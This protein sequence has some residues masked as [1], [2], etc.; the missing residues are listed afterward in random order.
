MKHRK[1]VQRTHHLRPLHLSAPVPQAVFECWH[2]AD[3]H[4]AQHVPHCTVNCLKVSGGDLKANGRLVHALRKALTGLVVVRCPFGRGRQPS[5]PRV[6]TERRRETVSALFILRRRHSASK[7]RRRCTASCH[8]S[9][10]FTQL[11]VRTSPVTIENPPLTVLP[12]K[13]LRISRA[14]VGTRGGT[15]VVDVGYTGV[16][17]AANCRELHGN[18]LCRLQP[19]AGDG[20]VMFKQ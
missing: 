7:R 13:Y 17:R 14:T 6:H 2:T 16:L 4:A 1:H 11:V 15:S 18:L 3:L 9:L 19:L 20:Y 8:N 5:E 12:N 10:W